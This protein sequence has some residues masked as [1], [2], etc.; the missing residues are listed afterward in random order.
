[1]REPDLEQELRVLLDRAAPRLDAPPHRMA[2]IRRRVSLRR[3]RRAAM[4]GAFAATVAV[5]GLVRPWAPAPDTGTHAASSPATFDA[6]FTDLA[7]LVM[8]VPDGWDSVTFAPPT[9]V[10]T[11]GYVSSQKLTFQPPCDAPLFGEDCPTPDPETG[12]PDVQLVV[13]FRLTDDP[14]HLAGS[15]AQLS[16]LD[17]KDT[18]CDTF[19]MKARMSWALTAPDDA[20]GNGRAIQATVCDNDPPDELMR[21]AQG[22][23][24]SARFGE[25][26]TPVPKTTAYLK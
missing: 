20:E 22:I 16:P 6:Q 3:R 11:I 17:V 1:M 15:V 10:P 9:D 7:N 12:F 25:G 23:V 4:V 14:T 19:G 24:Q 18:G 8:A 26:G 2:Q 5:V 13:A 21:L